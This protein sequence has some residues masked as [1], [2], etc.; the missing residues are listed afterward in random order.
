MGERQQV[1]IGRETI[2]TELNWTDQ[3]SWFSRNIEVKKRRKWRTEQNRKNNNK[4]L[5][6]KNAF[7]LMPRKTHRKLTGWLCGAV[8]VAVAVAAVVAIVAVVAVCSG[9]SFHH[10]TTNGMD[11]HPHI[12]TYWSMCDVMRSTCVCL[13]SHF[14][15][16]T[17]TRKTKKKSN[18]KIYEKHE[19]FFHFHF[20]QCI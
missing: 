6:V 15:T 9:S 20:L 10:S 1:Q 5:I 3:L 12:Y 17:F 16:V 8:A 14:H 18:K 2:R 4:F 7:V 19:S 13:L 11:T